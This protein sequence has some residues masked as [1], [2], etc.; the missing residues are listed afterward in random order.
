[1]AVC[2]L[3]EVA[4]SDFERHMRSCKGKVKCDDCDGLFYAKDC[5]LSDNGDDIRHRIMTYTIVCNNCYLNELGEEVAQEEPEASDCDCCGD[6]GP[7]SESGSE[8]ESGSQSGS[9]SDSE[10]K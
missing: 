8:S 2:N 9:E 5:H 1:M 7:G 4:Y 3:C 6:E 10:S